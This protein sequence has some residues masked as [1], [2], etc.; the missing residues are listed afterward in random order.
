[1]LTA[2]QV[3]QMDNERLIRA[4]ASLIGF[5]EDDNLKGMKRKETVDEKDLVKGEILRRMET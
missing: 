1:M 2:E 4:Y 3:K 5:I